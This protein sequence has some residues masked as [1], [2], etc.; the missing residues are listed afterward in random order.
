MERLADRFGIIH[1]GLLR[2]INTP[3]ELGSIAPSSY[4]VVSEGGTALEN[5]VAQPGQ[6]WMQ[7]ITQDQLWEALERVHK[8][9]HRLIE[10]KPEGG[11]LE[12]AF[13]KF[14]DQD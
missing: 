4:V 10:A 5:A 12:L 2:A 11:S 14:V 7:K 9:G 3:M 8:A 13:L 1:K 6:R